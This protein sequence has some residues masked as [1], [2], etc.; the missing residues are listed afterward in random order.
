MLFNPSKKKENTHEKLEIGSEKM[1][2]NRIKNLV[3]KINH[4]QGKTEAIKNK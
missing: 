2:K 3:T 4:K 1:K